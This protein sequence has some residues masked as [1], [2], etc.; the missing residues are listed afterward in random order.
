MTPSRATVILRREWEATIDRLVG[1]PPEGWSQPTRCEGW[2]VADLA[3]HMAWGASFEAD[4]LRRARTAAGGVAQGR[5]VD[6]DPGR[7]PDAVT[8]AVAD[9]WTEVARAGTTPVPMPYG[10]IEPELA[11]SIFVMEAAVHGS[12]LSAALGHD[13]RLAG[14]VVAPIALVLSAFL[15]V[16][17]TG[18]AQPPP[19]NTSYLLKGDSVEIPLMHTAGG[20]A[21]GAVESPTVT[22]AGSDSQVLLFALGRRPLVGLTVTGPRSLAESFKT[23]LPGL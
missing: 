10:E 9:L 19:P 21:A 6:P 14:D 18:A 4:G 22:I 12:D 15:P 1:M 7:L 8:S 17:A 5:T 13:D 11:L 3:A 20:W 16:T 2:T 23:H